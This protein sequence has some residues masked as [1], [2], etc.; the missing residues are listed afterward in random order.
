MRNFY[1]G[2]WSPDQEWVINHKLIGW[3]ETM[4]TYFLAIASP[5]HSVEVSYA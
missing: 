5:A 3:N 2:H 1:F 4:I